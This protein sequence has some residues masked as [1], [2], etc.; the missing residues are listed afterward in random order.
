MVSEMARRPRKG[1]WYILQTCA[2]VCMCECVC[3]YDVVVSVYI[4]EKERARERI[5]VRVCIDL[6]NPSTFHLHSIGVPNQIPSC[7]EC[8]CKS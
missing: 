5:C 4:Q 8:V 3:V 1:T 6:G 7:L 2:R